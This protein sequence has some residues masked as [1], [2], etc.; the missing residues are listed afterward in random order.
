MITIII[1]TLNSSATISSLLTSI[2]NLKYKSIE[3][4]VID[5]GSID[6]TIQIIN[7]FPLVKIFHESDFPNP[8]SPANA[9]NIGIENSTG[10]YLIFIDS[11]MKFLYTNT[12]LNINSKVTYIPFVIIK[13]TPLE[14]FIS[15]IINGGTYIFHRSFIANHR[16][17]TSLG[18]GEDRL[19]VHDIKLTSDIKI[20]TL[21][22][23]RHY[24]HTFKELKSQ[25]QWYGRTIPNYLKLSNKSELIH[26]TLY[27]MFNILFAVFIPI[28]IFSIFVSTTF[29]ITIILFYLFLITIRFMLYKLK[30][31]NDFIYLIIYS[32][33]FGIYFTK[34][35]ISSIYNKH[36]GR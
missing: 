10:D 1:P 15:R 21:P 5:G 27:I 32:T 36:I 23:G 4:I 18:F 13:D 9:R 24:P 16:F 8:H 33:F 29:L 11:D 20:S 3:T 19:F 30:S 25:A 12:L 17:N 28:I 35:L 7:S 2:S 6:E 14:C 22:I 31:I 34:G 26:Q